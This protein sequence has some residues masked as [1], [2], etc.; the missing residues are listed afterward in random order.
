MNLFLAAAGQTSFWEA[1]W[2]DISER[3]F[4]M[5]LNNYENL[6]IG[7]RQGLLS[8][9]G[10]VLAMFA[11]LI[12]AAVV[13]MFDKK[14]LGGAVRAIIAIGAL[15]PETAKTVV[16][17]GYMKSPAVKSSLKKGILSRVVHCVERDEYEQAYEAH[18]EAYV[19]EHG[20]ERGLASLPPFQIDW[21]NHHFYI[22]DEEHYKA[23]VRFDSKG[24]NWFSLVIVI[25]VAV[26]GAAFTC[27]FLPDILQ[28]L[29]NFV[30]R[31]IENN[32][33][34]L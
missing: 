27:Y 13:M 19:A 33:N 6:G 32:S 8:V 26:I 7:S 34:V 4:S 28:F 18:R 10:M 11:G 25:I 17:L 5:D 30:G 22:P 15:S 29:D 1:L 12:V 2:K 16:E 21:E 3:W 20:S 9:R 23:E 31:V 14:K 24:A